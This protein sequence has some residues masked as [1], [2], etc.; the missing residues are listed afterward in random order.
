MAPW[1]SEI[2]QSSSCDLAASNNVKPDLGF[3]SA[4]A[5]QWSAVALSPDK[6]DFPLWIIVCCTHAHMRA[7][8]KKNWIT[9]P[10]LT[11]LL[12][13]KVFEN[14]GL[15]MWDQF[16]TETFGTNMW[17]KMTDVYRIPMDLELEAQIAP[18]YFLHGLWYE[19]SQPS[20]L[21]WL[22]TVSHNNDK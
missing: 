2:F 20:V 19:E 17:I 14:L 1:W 12:P 7:N 9:S 22:P 8:K 15:W 6:K 16:V 5:K 18:G 3:S 4:H 11:C 21:V 13:T 10:D